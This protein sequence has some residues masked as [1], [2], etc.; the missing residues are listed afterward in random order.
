MVGKIG[1]M[2]WENPEFLREGW[3]LG[4]HGSARKK[5]FNPWTPSTDLGAEL[6]EDQRRPWTHL[7][8][9]PC[10]DRLRL[11]VGLSIAVSVNV[12]PLPRPGAPFPHTLPLCRDVLCVTAVPRS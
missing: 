1:G 4:I 3:L 2:P 10:G 7:C 9:Q 8:L 5:R 11:E 6:L 12:A